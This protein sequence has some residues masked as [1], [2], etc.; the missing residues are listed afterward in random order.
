[1][2]VGV[3]GSGQLALMLAQESADTNIEVIPIGHKISD[4]LEQYCD[5]IYGDMNDPV[6]L[7]KFLAHVDVVTY[8]T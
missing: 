2:K 8:E 1:M 6:L 7:E 5:P 4:K 3:L